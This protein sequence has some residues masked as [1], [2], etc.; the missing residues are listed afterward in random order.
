MES[1]HKWVMSHTLIGFAHVRHDSSVIKMF[2]R[3]DTPKICAHVCHFLRHM[4]HSCV[5][6]TH[7]CVWHDSFVWHDSHEWV[8][9]THTWMSH[10]HTWTHF[11][12]GRLMSL[13][14]EWCTH[15]T[16]SKVTW[17]DHMSRPWMSHVHTW[18]IQKWHA[19]IIYKVF[20]GSDTPKVWAHV[21]CFLRDMN[22]L[23][24]W[25][26]YMTELYVH[27]YAMGW[28]WVAA[29]LKL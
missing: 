24:V 22:D 8:M 29:C 21:C 15:M 19:S 10:V 27:T 6:I 25:H 23:C 4:T 12:Y 1:C 9:Y 11:I 20:A 16:H 5:Y 3:S 28:L 18:L 14:N 26:N 13:L 7:S 17:V 2:A